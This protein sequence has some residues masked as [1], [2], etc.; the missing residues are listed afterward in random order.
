MQLKKNFTHLNISYSVQKM[1]NKFKK[2][3]LTIDQLKKF[4]VNYDELIFGKP[5]YDVFVDDKNLS[6]KND[7][8]K[9]ILK[10]IKKKI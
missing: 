7:W 5:S 9:D 8:S 2:K 6:F 4:R 10:N 3:I 1:N